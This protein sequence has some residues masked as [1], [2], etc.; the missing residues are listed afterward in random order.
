MSDS[1]LDWSAWLFYAGLALY[2][3]S[4]PWWC[5]P[6][7]GLRLLVRVLYVT[8]LAARAL[9]LLRVLSFLPGRP[10]YAL[11]CICL[12]GVLKLSSV[13]AVQSRSD[14]FH[15]FL[16]LLASRDT[17]VRISLK[18]VLSSI[19]FFLIVCPVSFALGWNG[20]QV[21]HIG[22]MRGTSLGFDN[23]N[24]FA[25]FIMTAAFCGFSLARE[26]RM[27]VICMVCS[28]LAV[29]VWFLT[30]CKTITICLLVLPLLFALFMRWSNHKI[31]AAMP[32]ACLLLS[33]VLAAVYGPGYGGNTFESRFTIPALVYQKCGLSLFGQDCGLTEWLTG[34]GPTRLSI[35]NCYLNIF[36]C[37]GIVAGLFAM[38]FLTHLMLLIAR[39]GNPLLAAMAC[40]II[41]SGIMESWVFNISL[42]FIPF[43][44][45]SLLT[46]NKVAPTLNIRK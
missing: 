18:I 25:C 28:A 38:A 5:A 2:L 3:F 7:Q 32:A 35:D 12:L 19:V 16:V 30:L 23:P 41:I 15:F 34:E 1:K 42:N 24:S 39:K 40:V 26:K 9:L 46:G 21:K 44:F 36:L 8:G 33:L 17:D 22:Q 13:L 11:V 43:F 29:L 45:F 10:R 31:V 14:L 20:E 37:N 27:S 4:V 6:E